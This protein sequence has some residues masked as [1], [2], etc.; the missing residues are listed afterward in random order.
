MDSEIAKR[1][2]VG[3]DVGT[4]SARAGL[5]STTGKLINLSKKD[6][7]NDQ[8]PEGYYEQSTTDIWSSV[9]AAVKVK[10]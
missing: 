3:V 1:W 7:R 4:G 8:S 2:F 9:C 10:L 5:F 6:I